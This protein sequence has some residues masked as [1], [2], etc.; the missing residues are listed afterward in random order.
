[1]IPPSANAS[2]LP[3]TANRF[4]MTLVGGSEPCG[5]ESA[6]QCTPARGR[7]TGYF[8]STNC[9]EPLFATAT[10]CRDGRGWNSRAD[11]R[12]GRGLR[13][14][15]ESSLEVDQT[16]WVQLVA[17]VQEGTRPEGESG[18]HR[19]SGSCPACE[20]TRHETLPVLAGRPGGC[21]AARLGRRVLPAALPAPDVRARPAGL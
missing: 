5:R 6:A 19:L 15:V 13:R 16:K 14:H 10:G 1:M 2:R 20:G 8:T 18:R 12:P 9:N 4:M 11:R 3:V 17:P 7:G 21:G